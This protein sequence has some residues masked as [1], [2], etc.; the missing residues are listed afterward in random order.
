ML[1]I[2]GVVEALIEGVV[3]ALNV[4]VSLRDVMP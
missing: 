2:E 1:K 3:E 4:T